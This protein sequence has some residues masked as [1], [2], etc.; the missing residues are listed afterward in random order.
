MED[1]KSY[2]LADLLDHQPDAPQTLPAG[3]PEVKAE[4]D[5][6]KV[7]ASDEH[8]DAEQE[9]GD[10]ME[11]EDEVGYLLYISS[12]PHLLVTGLVASPLPAGR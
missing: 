12:N 9:G 1:P 7:N 5:K 10:G 6:E 11:Q 2:P 3:A 4:S 8:D